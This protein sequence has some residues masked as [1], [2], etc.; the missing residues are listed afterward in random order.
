MRRRTSILIAAACLLAAFSPST[1]AGAGSKSPIQITPI[2]GYF[3][4]SQFSTTYHTIVRLDLPQSGGGVNIEW[5]LR[6]KLVDRAGAPDPQSFGSGA[7]VDA[8]CTNHGDLEM[9]DALAFNQKDAR[10]GR[11]TFF[12]WHHPDAQDSVPVGWY[13]CNH[14]LQGPHGHQGLITVVVSDEGWKCVATFK[15]THSSVPTSDGTNLNVKN[16]TASEPKCS[17]T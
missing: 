17:K 14:E 8:A 6:L 11:L 7:G 9:S 16:G 3:N 1:V 4:A 2:V 15:G 5:S 12:T 10:E 13:H